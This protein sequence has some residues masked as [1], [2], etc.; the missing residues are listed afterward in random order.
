[1]PGDLK[2]KIVVVNSIYFFGSWVIP[3]NKTYTMPAEFT[4]PDNKKT[5][6]SA[7]RLCMEGTCWMRLA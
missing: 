3:F 7:L 2:F 5:Q 6:V 1:V 4:T